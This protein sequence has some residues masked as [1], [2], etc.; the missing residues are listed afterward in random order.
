MV[1]HNKKVFMNSKCWKFRSWLRNH[2]VNVVRIFTEYFNYGFTEE[3]WK[4]YCERQLQMRLESTMLAKIKTVADP[5]TANQA[6][7]SGVTGVQGGGV[8]QQQQH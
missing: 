1:L 3:T 7:D 2:G 4:L 8:T 5:S 6:T